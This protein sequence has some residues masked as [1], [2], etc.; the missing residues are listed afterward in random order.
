M[1]GENITISLTK[2]RVEIMDATNTKAN[3]TLAVIEA[4]NGIVHVIDKVLLPQ[5]IIDA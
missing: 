5:E 2:N 1:L 4:S 3:V